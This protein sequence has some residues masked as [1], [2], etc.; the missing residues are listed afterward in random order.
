MAVIAPSI[1]AADFARLGEALETI[2]AAGASMVHVDV[3]DGHFTPQLTAGQP[4]VQSLRRATDLVLDVHLLIERP[5]RYALEF[6]DAGADRVSVQ[7]EATTNLH[8]VLTAVRAR[9]AQAGVGVNPS[10]RLEALADVLEELDFVIILASDP[11]IEEQA[12]IPESVEKV[13]EAARLRE[14]RRLSFAVQVEGGV[15]F[16]R[17]E[18]F[19]RAGAD[20]LVAGSAIFH[21]ENPRARLEE[22]IRLAAGTRQVS[23]V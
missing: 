13:R 3:M 12:F 6:V 23:K 2:K 16:G 4:V 5:E 7:A 22:M 11:G 10:T 20:I 18:N 19:V 1:L 15:S 17:V 21:K 14:T 8:A 9:G